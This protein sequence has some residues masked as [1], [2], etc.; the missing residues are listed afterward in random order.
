[1][2]YS[3]RACYD[4]PNNTIHFWANPILPELTEATIVGTLCHEVNHWA[5]WRV[6]RF[7]DHFRASPLLEKVADWR[8][9]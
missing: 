3:A 5:Q 9:T 7:T 4:I 2:H 8:D 1:M 6:E